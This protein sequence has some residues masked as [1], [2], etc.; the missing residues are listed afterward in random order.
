MVFS[1]SVAPNFASTP[2]IIN[3]LINIHL[4]FQSHFHPTLL[5]ESAQRLDKFFN[6]ITYTWY[7]NAHVFITVPIHTSKCRLAYLQGLPGS[8][9]SCGCSFH[10]RYPENIGVHRNHRDAMIPWR[11]V[12]KP[13][14]LKWKV[15]PGETK[16]V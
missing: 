5:L 16:M 11:H 1:S 6:R 9:S 3:Y 8:F 4:C 14:S 7:K 15:A 10:S 13:Q 2:H 12:T